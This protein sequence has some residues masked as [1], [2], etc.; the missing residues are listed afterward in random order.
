MNR[1]QLEALYAEL[2]GQAKIVPVGSIADERLDAKLCL[3]EEILE[4]VE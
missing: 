4:L 3:L 2:L 1:E